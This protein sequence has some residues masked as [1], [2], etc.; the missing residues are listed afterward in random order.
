MNN[1]PAT[2]WGLPGLI[3][4]VNDGDLRILCSKIVLNPKKKIEIKA[5]DKGKV[6]SEAKF[7]EI[8]RKKMKEM[9]DR[10]P[11][12]SDGNSFEIRVRG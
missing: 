5:P 2:Y 3:M 12:R 7:E 4:E 9:Q 6:V 1:G 10:M 8:M 11:R